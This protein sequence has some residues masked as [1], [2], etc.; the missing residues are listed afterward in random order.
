MYGKSLFVNV[1]SSF[2]CSGEGA[3]NVATG[4]NRGQEVRV[5]GPIGAAGQMRMDVG[6][7]GQPGPGIAFLVIA[8]AMNTNLSTFNSAFPL[9]AEF[10][11]CTFSG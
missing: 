1:Y 9:L 6:F 2:L 5:N 8:K 3:I 10:E 11:Q 4:P 7:P